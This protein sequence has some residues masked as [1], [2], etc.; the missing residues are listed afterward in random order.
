MKKIKKAFVITSLLFFP[1]VLSLTGCKKEITE[2]IK[3]GTVSVADGITGGKVSA[4]K[5][6]NVALDTEI[7]IL[8]SPD[9]GYQVESYYLNDTKLESNTFKVKVKCTPNL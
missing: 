1:S 7:T 3:Y 5:V 6:G 8:A 9:N 4:S 2:P